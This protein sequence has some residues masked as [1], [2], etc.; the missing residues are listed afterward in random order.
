MG[1]N[2]LNKF[3]SYIVN[4]KPG[5]EKL[6]LLIFICFFLIACP[7]TIIKAIR[8][9]DLLW[10]IGTGG[11][12][13]AYLSAAVI[14]GLVVLFHSRI[15]HRISSQLMFTA[16]L[17][18]FIITGMLLNFLLMTNY[19]RDSVFLSYLFWVW[20]NV[21][22]IVLIPQF[23]LIINEVFNLREA[24]RLIGFCG[25]GG[26]LGGVVGGLLAKYLTQANLASLLLPI[27]CAFLFLCIFVVR[28]INATRQKTPSSTISSAQKND[29]S[30]AP[31]VGFMD[32]F[33]TV[34]ESKYLVLISGLVIFTVIV[35][36]FIDF[37]FSSA[38][39]ESYFFKEEKQAFFGLFYAG[40]MTFSFFL[41]LL[42]TSKI[43][44]AYRVRPPMLITP[45]ALIL[46]SLTILFM[47]FTMLLAIF[48]KGSEE[49]LGYTFNQPVR[50]ILYIPLAPDLK[51]KVKP[52]IDMLIN[53]FAK[54]L[55][56]ILLLL[57]AFILNKE[58]DFLT[59]TLDIEFSKDLIWGII[60]LSIVWVII[61]LSLSKE[62]NKIIKDKIEIVWPDPRKELKKLDV[63]L[64]KLVFDTVESKSHSSVLFAMHLFDL[65]ERGKL[66]PEIKQMFSQR[67]TEM[68]AASLWNIL[69]AEGATWIPEE[70]DDIS[71]EH[72]IANIRDIISSDAYQKVMRLYTDQKAEKGELSE[73]EK[74]EMAKGIGMMK[75]DDPMVEKLES[76]ISDESPGVSCY[77]LR[78]AAKLKKVEHI[79]AI[80]QKLIDP[81]THDDAVSALEAYG[82]L[83]MS[84]L[85]ECLCNS[86]KDIRLRKGTVEVLSNIGSPKAVKLL[87]RELD[88]NEE[89]LENEIIDA[90]DHIRSERPDIYFPV[91]LAKRATLS[92]I[93]KYCQ[94]FIDLQNLEP[95]KK[96]EELEYRMERDLKT[97]L[98][99]IFKLMG[100]Y[101]PHEDITKA[102]QNLKKGTNESIDD[103][104]ELLDITL[105]KK[106]R[107]IILPLIEDLHPL[108][109]RRKFQKILRKLDTE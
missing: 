104:I 64:T 48:I 62:H 102:S 38:V 103:A 52:F 53:R 68:S 12:P 85:E 89:E 4:V 17:V 84:Q 26:I 8:Y 24:K 71:P 82:N 51:A 78:S 28:A 33:N 87:T 69:G 34:R 29:T 11:L 46:C 3:L 92:L 19:G 93:K 76:L 70:E 106:M 58:V 44:N 67:P 79:P 105:D 14:T 5:E 108:D 77:A 100:L 41:S 2:R 107:S 35:S 15:H 60:V 98:K 54:V 73:K 83:A 22:V 27:G 56:A 99:N 36:T 6:V 88:Q 31:K 20:A 39:H 37:Q 65:I 18:F 74:M 1:K 66:T 72:L 75:P 50:E 23:F 96:S 32:T 16:S 90:L 43:L 42:L 109:R 10:K 45:A 30:E 86:E 59:P 63:D 80:L 13:I 7:Y 57:F 81:K 95:D 9:A 61:G 101:Y 55:A 47:P 91:K 21:L 40:L 25:S 94:I 97:H 49:S